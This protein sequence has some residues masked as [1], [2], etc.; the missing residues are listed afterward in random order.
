MAFEWPVRA[1]DLI[2]VKIN[3]NIDSRACENTKR[4]SGKFP[5]LT[6]GIKTIPQRRS[7][8]MY[9][10]EAF[11][12]TV[13][14]SAFGEEARHRTAVWSLRTDYGTAAISFRTRPIFSHSLPLSSFPF[15]LRT[16]RSPAQITSLNI[17]LTDNTP[18]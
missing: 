17:K 9:H 14:D 6:S 1:A 7:A 12:I 8:D 11:M 16:C 18:R 3:D 4:I 13:C 10:P 5:N 2:M 15:L